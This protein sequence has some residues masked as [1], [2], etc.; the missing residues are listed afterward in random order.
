MIFNVYAEQREEISGIRLVSCGHIFAKSGRT[1]CRP[2]GRNDWLLF[3]VSKENES[4]FFER[5]EVAYSGSFVIFA[6]GEKQ[7]HIYKGSKTAEFYYIHFRCEDFSE[8]FSFE[9]SHI[10]NTPFN[11]QVCD[12]FEDMIEE[13]LQKQPFHEKMCIYK[14]LGLLTLLER[15]TVCKIPSERKKFDHIAR[16][17][18]HMNRNYNSDLSLEDYA[19]MCNMSKYHFLRT[20][21][22]IVG[23]TPFEYRNDIRLEHA[24]MLLNEERLSMEDLSATVGY[25]SA[26]YFSSAFKNKFGISPKQYQQQNTDK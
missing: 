23:S 15:E 10:Y 25:S 9:T 21:K 24:A 26:S 22:E 6:P 11:R 16:A 7:H 4:F 13:L 17:V 3:F 20:F 2:Q 19:A 18:Q 5:E 12:I 1:I 8:K 14:L